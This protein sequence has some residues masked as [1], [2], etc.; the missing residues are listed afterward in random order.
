MCAKPLTLRDR[1]KEATSQEILVA[2]EALI[3][4]EGFAAV[5]MA[6]VAQRA[7]VSVGTL[8]NYYKDKDELLGT[9]ITERRAQFY[10]ELSAILT[11]E[12]SL[13]FAARLE[14]IVAAIF[15]LYDSRRSFLRLVIENDW[16]AVPGEP[17]A[18]G[19]KKLQPYWQFVELLRPVMAKGVKDGA[20][21]PEGAQFYPGFLAGLVRA[22]MFEW[23]AEDGRSY[24][25]ATE[26]VTNFF[27]KGAGRPA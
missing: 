25:D 14:G 17:P 3:A 7:G 26:T 8:Y 2:A 11:A 22:T 27:L 4:D 19:S 16:P 13:P 24:S 15:K 5:S 18:K 9:L 23:L 10:A 1:L 20:L 12:R 6:K 21:A